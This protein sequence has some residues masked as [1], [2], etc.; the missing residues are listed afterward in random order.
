M[1]KIIGLSAEVLGSEELIKAFEAL[2]PRLQGKTFRA[3][4][5]QATKL[6]RKAVLARVPVDSGNLK[7]GI[8]ARSLPRSRKTIGRA[9]YLPERAA[10][11]IDKDD[12][13]YYPAFAEYGTRRQPAKPFLR[14]AYDANEQA[15]LEVLRRE[16]RKGIDE[17]WAKGKS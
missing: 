12:K 7:K 2:E 9:V 16:I 13:W 14:P 17:A 5:T 10:L 11:G 15:A 6:I 3:A 1:A 4:T 8:K